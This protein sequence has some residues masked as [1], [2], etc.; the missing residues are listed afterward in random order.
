MGRIFFTILAVF[1]ITESLYADQTVK[2]GMNYPQT[3]PYKFIGIDQE[4]G[5]QLA[6]DEINGA[7]GILGR[8][9]EIFRRDSK[10][11]PVRSAL[12]ATELIEQ[13]GVS[14]VFGGASSQVAIRVSDVCQQEGIPFMATV[15]SAN[16]TTGK[17]GHRHTFR[18]C[19]SAWMGAK[20]LGVFLRK[21]FPADT[22]RYFFIVADY[23][24]GRSAEASIRKFS[25]AENRDIHH[26]SYTRFPGI[27]EQSLI[28][29]MQVARI[30]KA[31]VLVLCHFGDD[32][33]MA[34][35][36]ATELGLKKDMQIV[37]PI[38]ELSMCEGAGPENM[39]DIV[40]TSDFNWQVPFAYDYKKGKDFVGRFADRYGRYPCWGAA[41]A[42]TILWEYKY[43]VERAGSF[44]AVDVIQSLEGHR[45][46]LLKDEQEWRKF[47]HQN[48]QTVY[49]VKC[50]QKEDVIKDR[51]QLDYF[52]II[53]SLPGNDAVRTYDE[54][55][56]ARLE[57][58]LPPYFEKLP[59]E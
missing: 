31:N 58:G 25:G 19:Y 3:G 18:T 14:M 37:V 20:A 42:Y 45:F 52:E 36:V 15:T 48:I 11:N 57:D 59:G 43:A 53:D 17:S 47:D 21:H 35:R 9:I 30:R 56:A 54:W 40:G 50:K 10:S 26:V 2:I 1:L 34:V 23:S 46:S 16:E 5:A 39:E 27:T 28:N 4:R 29:K 7:G 24:W 55:K 6:L 33:T 38:L 12:N 44:Q 8:R 49:L 22:N 13:K 51:Y 32:L 41:K